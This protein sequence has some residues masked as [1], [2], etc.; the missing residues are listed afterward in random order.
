MQGGSPCQIPP[1]RIE[2]QIII[3]KVPDKKLQGEDAWLGTAYRLKDGKV[4]Y[5]PEGDAEK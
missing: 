2:K 4:I 5:V 1:G 3:E